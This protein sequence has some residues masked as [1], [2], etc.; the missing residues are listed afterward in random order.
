MLDGLVAALKASPDLTDDV[1]I[2]DGQPVKD[3]APDVI[4]VAYSPDEPGVT[5]DV[6]S[7]L[8]DRA[9]RYNVVFLASSWRG[10]TDPVQVRDRAFELVAAIDTVLRKDK[11]L[12][13]AAAG[14]HVTAR[15]FDQAQVN[16]GASA[17]V[18]GTIHVDA[19]L[20]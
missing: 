10:D 12:G 3:V 1:Q 15:E 8:A 20:R 2:I 5:A 7:G 19:F 4:I 13:G 6:T 18:K 11:T 16:E 14:T 9:E 17:T